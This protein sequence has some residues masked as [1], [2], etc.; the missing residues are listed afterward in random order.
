MA[1]M[2]RDLRIYEVAHHRNGVGG[3]PFYAVRFADPAECP[4]VMLG[5][6]FQQ[7]GQVAVLSVNKLAG[8]GQEATVA[9][10]ENSWRGDVYEPAL[11]AAI[12][13]A[14]S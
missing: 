1:K 4:G 14:E 12:K 13:E 8:L 5:I 9:F 2:L 6:V 11:R 7:A 3:A 10:G